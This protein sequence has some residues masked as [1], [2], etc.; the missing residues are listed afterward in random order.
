VFPIGVLKNPKGVFMSEFGDV[1]CFV[2]GFFNALAEKMPER[3]SELKSSKNVIE[4]CARLGEVVS[5]E[6]NSDK[7][8]N[9]TMASVSLAASIINHI[10][11]QS[12]V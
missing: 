2:E 9:I 1:H 8:A 10:V 11:V 4:S 12:R 5:Q 7:A 6:S 3:A